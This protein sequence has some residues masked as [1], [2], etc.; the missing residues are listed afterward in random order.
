MPLAT[1]RLCTKSG[2]VEEAVVAPPAPEG[3]GSRI[4]PIW[5][6]LA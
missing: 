5:A 4:F 6:K 1:F 3:P 2:Q